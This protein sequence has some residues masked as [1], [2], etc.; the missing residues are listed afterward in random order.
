MKQLFLI[1]LFYTPFLAFSDTPHLVTEVIPLDYRTVNEIIPVLRP[2]VTP[3]GSVSGLQGQLVVT[4]TPQGMA[5]VR[6]V[7]TSLDNAPAS[8]LISVSRGGSKAVSQ[9]SAS[10][11]GQVGTIAIESGGVRVGSSTDHKGETVDALSVQANVNSRSETMNITQQVQV[12]EGGEAYI[13]IGEEIPVR[14]R[15]S[16]AGA[17]GVYRYNSTEFYPAVTGF[18]AIPRL[19]GDEVILEINFVSR[20]RNTI[21]TNGRLDRQGGQSVTVSDIKTSVSGKLGDWIMLGNVDQS[22]SIIGSSI[23]GASRQQQNSNSMVFLR[24]EKIQN[25]N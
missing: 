20:M 19:H 17:G 15:G 11:Q 23:A 12:L 2:L 7:L 8:L 3:A 13:S 18:Y 22:G 21:K 4:A 9:D 24:V 1:F 6:K 16:V 10:V 25:G 5:A 14:N